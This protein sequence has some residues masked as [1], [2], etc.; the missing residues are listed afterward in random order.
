MN[1]SGKDKK[2]DRTK[3]IKIVTWK[4]L[5]KYSA[6]QSYGDFF[7]SGNCF[8]LLGEPHG[9]LGITG[10]Y[11]SHLQDSHDHCISIL[12]SSVTPQFS[13]TSSERRH[14][15]EQYSEH[16]PYLSQKLDVQIHRASNC[17]GLF[18]FPLTLHPICL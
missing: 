1:E 16:S 12:S 15:L 14:C 8:C 11:S 17:S 3:I 13:I 9:K 10:H 6:V 18:Y 4:K 7:H 2:S 5:C